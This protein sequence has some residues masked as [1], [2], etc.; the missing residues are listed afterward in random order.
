MHDDAGGRGLLV[1]IAD[2][3]RGDDDLADVEVLERHGVE[4]RGALLGEHRQQLLGEWA[5]VDV[6]AGLR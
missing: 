4:Q 1:V 2:P 5:V 6:E 3:L